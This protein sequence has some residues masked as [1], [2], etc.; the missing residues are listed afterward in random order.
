MNAVDWRLCLLLSGQC[1]EPFKS[2]VAAHTPGIRVS[3][4]PGHGSSNYSLTIKILVRE[5]IPSLQ[6]ASSADT[7][8]HNTLM[9][10]V[11]GTCCFP[12]RW[13]RSDC[14]SLLHKNEL[15]ACSWELS[16]CSWRT[17]KKFQFWNPYLW[18]KKDLGHW[19]NISIWS[20]IYT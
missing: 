9:N 8:R 18:G 2:G 6:A 7:P 12:L 14:H 16:I 3:F 13:G 1:L 19:A 17:K 10:S 20:C 5:H 15:C 4:Y 11:L